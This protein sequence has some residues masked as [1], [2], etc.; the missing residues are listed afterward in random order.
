MKFSNK[1]KEGNQSRTKTSY[2]K[3]V[4]VEGGRKG[5]KKKKRDEKKR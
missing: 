2:T 1:I 3:E 5:K 4:E